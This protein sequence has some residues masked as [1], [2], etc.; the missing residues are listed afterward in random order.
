MIPEA[1]IE[2]ATDWKQNHT[3]AA[4]AWCRC[5]APWATSMA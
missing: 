2:T 3:L 4:P 1:L 5:S